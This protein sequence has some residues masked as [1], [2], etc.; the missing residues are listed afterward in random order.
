MLEGLLSRRR[1]LRQLSTVAISH[2][3][4]SRVHDPVEGINQTTS[5]EKVQR[6]PIIYCTDL[7]HPHDDPDDHFDL[8]TLFALPELE[9]KAILLDQ[10]EKQ[11]QKPGRI[12]LEQIFHLTGRRVPY[13]IGLSQ[14]LKSLSDMGKDQPSKFQGAV[15]LLLETLND[16]NEPV[17]IVTTGSVRDVCAA[18]N[19]N[20]DL[21]L[22]KVKRLYLNI[23]NAEVGGSEYNV[24]LDP[25][26]YV[27]L[28]RSGLQIYFCPCLPMDSRNIYSTY[29]RFRQGDILES[30]PLGLQ[31]FF[32]YALQVVRPDEI[33][34]IKALTMNLRPFRHLVWQMERNMWSTASLIAAA[35]REIYRMEKGYVAS[36]QP[37]TDWQPVKLFSFV[38]ARVEVDEIGRT[39][40]VTTNASKANVLIFVTSE[41][42]RY[43]KAMC[44]ILKALLSQFPV[45]SEIR[46]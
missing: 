29:W 12:S 42:E 32:I 38:P 8:A 37:L 24:D 23:G 43:S 6:V 5:V 20:P 44:D 10:G 13:A 14:K 2:A 15:E 16:A 34:S 19:R 30:V 7:F 22:T 27:G 1:F 9:V 40:E 35:G 25:N 17:V 21:F 4:F 31:N 3:L 18:F 36:S 11:E 41:A 39:K 46:P 33:D 26:A 45:V 28:L